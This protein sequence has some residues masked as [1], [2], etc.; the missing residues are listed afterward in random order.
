MS[1]NSA[2]IS[3]VKCKWICDICDEFDVDY[4][5]IQ[6]HF[7]KTKTIDKYFRDNFRGYS[8]YV[9][10]GYRAPGQDS[11]RCRA[12]LAQL[13]NKSYSVKKE[14][15]TT[16][17]F[18]IQAQVLCMPNCR[19]LWM[20]TYMPTDP[21]RLTEYDDSDLQEV[22]LEVETIL[23]CCNYT[24]V[25]WSGDLN[26]DMSRVTYFS[27]TMAKFV[28]KLGLV[29]LWSSKPVKYTYM[30]TDNKSVSVLDHF[31]LSPR[32]LQLV[33]GC[34]AV[35]RGDNLSGH[36][37]IWVKLKLGTLPAKKATSSWVPR[38]PSWCKA[39]GEQIL[40][41]DSD[42]ER[43]L[44]GLNSPLFAL[45]CEDPHCLDASHSEQRD[46]FMLDILLSLVECTYTTLPIS[47][48]SGGGGHGGKGKA[49]PIPGWASVEPFRKEAQYWHGVWLKENRPSR[50]WLHDTMTK[51]KRQYHY[52]VRR[53]KASS[54]KVRAVRLFEAAMKGDTDLLLEMKK[55][56]SGGCGNK[57]EL[58]DNV[59]DADG[60]EEIVDK[61]REVYAALYSS[62]R[63]EADMEVLRHKVK[64]LIG[65]NS[66]QEVTKSLAL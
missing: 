38:K 10:P 9:I 33:V 26:W 2:G 32:L 17:G 30:H 3:T 21:K 35:E 60:E 15:I 16:K 27:R 45:S 64:N 29:S 42:L 44:L 56:R 59:A 37:P 14:R 58:P 40:N 20:N 11:G 41:Y 25:I 6:E 36:C 50:G 31:L 51:W 24:D 22:L 61:F 49:A 46:A 19:L 34:G 47:G 5:A 13:S 53:A 23:S 48:G 63:S 7:K 65:A 1:C 52:A 39:N 8:S 18:R 54:N 12:G 66:V 55:I 57:G 28:E 62:A 43:S 4:L